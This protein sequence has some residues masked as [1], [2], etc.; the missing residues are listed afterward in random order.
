MSI[1]I[2]TLLSVASL[3]GRAR[4]L[5]ENHA[6]SQTAALWLCYVAVSAELLALQIHNVGT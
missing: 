1:V 3:L 5:R 6:V 2:A 4:I